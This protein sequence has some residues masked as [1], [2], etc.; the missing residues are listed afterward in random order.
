MSGKRAWFALFL[1]VVFLSGLGAGLLVGRQFEA[2]A[3]AANTGERTGG[4][5]AS[6]TP[7]AELAARLSREIGLSADQEQQLVTIFTERRARL[8]KLRE[9]VRQ[10][11]E[12]EHD[13]LR[14]EVRKA[15][16]PEQWTRYEEIIKTMRSREWRRDS[17]R[18]SRDGER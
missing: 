15:L 3:A 16:T 2:P 18:P 17:R 10:Q 5:R 13:E 12:A 7:P 1:A 14:A 4:R 9:D 8:R 6:S 11:F